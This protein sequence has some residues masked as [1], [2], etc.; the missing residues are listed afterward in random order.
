MLR[1]SHETPRKFQFDFQPTGAGDRRRQRN[2]TRV[3]SHV[4]KFQR[5]VVALSRTGSDLQSLKKKSTARQSW[6]NLETQRPP[7]VQL[8]WPVIS[9]CSSTR[10]IAILE[11]FLKITAEA[12]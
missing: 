7:H 11:P 2:W 6:P 4:T 10:A 3:R 1:A 12:W 5:Q 8:S 9:I